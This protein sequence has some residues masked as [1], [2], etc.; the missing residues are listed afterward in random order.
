MIKLPHIEQRVRLQDFTTMKIGGPADY[1][2]R[3]KDREAVKEACD[4]AAQE[5]LPVFVLGEGSNL[6]VA[7]APIHRLVVKME[8]KG[9]EKVSES[10]T[11]VTWRVGAGE[12]WDGV[13]ERAVKLGLSGIEA[14]SM[15]PGTMGAAPV[16]NAGAYGQEIAD[17]LVELDAFDMAEE[18]FVTM[19]RS[20]CD[21][22]YRTSTFK[23]DNAG[24]YVITSVT[25]R[26]SKLTPKRP[27]YESLRRWLDEHE[28]ADPTVEQIRAG[29][30][31]VR[32]VLQVP[33]R[34]PG[35]AARY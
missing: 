2:V 24:R 27:T 29:V 22:G 9:F 33:H 12:H 23:T 16:Q 31:T 34:Q 32:L 30:T 17:T 4:W 11:H 19:N 7:D 13:V 21:F 6:V 5:H 10:K 20:D 25:L 1:F 35:K 28:V 26:L 18:K 8:I 15:I 3:V 14:M